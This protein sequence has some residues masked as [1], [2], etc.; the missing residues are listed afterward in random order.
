[1]ELMGLGA[2][3]VTWN[4]GCGSGVPDRGLLVRYLARAAGRLA[5]TEP[6]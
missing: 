3:E 4:G 5:R 1:M 2:L 6:R